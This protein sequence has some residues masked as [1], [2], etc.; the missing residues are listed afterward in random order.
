MITLV[1]LKYRNVLP[2]SVSGSIV[3]YMVRDYHTSLCSGKTP[4]PKYD[5]S[6]NK[7]KYFFGRA[8]YLKNHTFMVEE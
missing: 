3:S 7:T 6:V 8:P 5:M 1:P 2:Q 4:Y